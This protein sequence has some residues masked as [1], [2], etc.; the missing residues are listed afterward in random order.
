MFY[1][2]NLVSV[3]SFQLCIVNSFHTDDSQSRELK[4]YGR[5]KCPVSNI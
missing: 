4:K 5:E 1:R 2:K 3:G